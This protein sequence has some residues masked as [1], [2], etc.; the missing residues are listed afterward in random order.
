MV[1]V[2]SHAESARVIVQFKNPTS[3]NAEAF[4]Q[5]LQT[6]TASTVH[7]VAAVSADTHVYIL[8]TPPGKSTTQLLDQLSALPEIARAEVDKKTKG[9]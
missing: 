2:P 5:R 6:L 8:K 3:I 9:R 4:A 7:Y 1:A